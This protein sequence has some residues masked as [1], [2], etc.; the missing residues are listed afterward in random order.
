MKKIVF[1]GTPDFSVPTLQNLYNDPDIDLLFVVT[2][3]DKKSERGMKVT[4]S[5]IKRFCIQNNIKYYQS[6]KLKNDKNLINIIKNAKPD[7]IIVVAFGEILSKEILEIPKACINGHASLLPKY[8]GSSPIQN[9]ILNGDKTTGVTTMLMSEGLDCGEKKKKKEIVLDGTETCGD[10]FDILSKMTADLIN[11][12]IKEYD[13]IKKIPQNEKDASYVKLV[14]KE[15]GYVDLKNEEYDLLYRKIR[16]YNPWPTV[17][18]KFDNKI[19]KLY[20]VKKANN[21]LFNDLI[22]IDDVF[23]I[24]NKNLYAKLKNEIIIILDLQFEGKKR[25]LAKDFIN[26]FKK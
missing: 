26:G 21:I 19:L 1:M 20:N 15:D 2:K 5:P 24:S 10:L 6:N 16:A 13:N 23:F 3:N 18:T 22:N 7:F 11:K 12:S 14:K 8:R 9:C 17:Y 25:M 4:F